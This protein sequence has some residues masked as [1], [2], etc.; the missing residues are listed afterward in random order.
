MDL[1][2]RLQ[3]HMMFTASDHHRYVAELEFDVGIHITG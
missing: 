3:L 2:L 1:E